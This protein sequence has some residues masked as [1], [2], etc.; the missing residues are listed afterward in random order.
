MKHN[1]LNPFPIRSFFKI[2]MLALERKGFLLTPFPS[3]NYTVFLCFPVN[4]KV[5]LLI[6]KPLAAC[7][8]QMNHI[9]VGVV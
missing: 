1:T 4:K 2:V 3:W 9:H 7:N 5:F 6:W 8:K